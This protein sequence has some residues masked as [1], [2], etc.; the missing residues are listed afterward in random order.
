MGEQD[1]NALTF[2]LGYIELIYDLLR[3]S[4][5]IGRGSLL[6]PA[7]LLLRLALWAMSLV[8]GGVGVFFA[9]TSFSMPNLG[10]HALVLLCA[11]LAINYFLDR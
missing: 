5:S 1:L 10:A 2:I 9:I 8:L 7:I 3:C 6:M 4:Y 11:A